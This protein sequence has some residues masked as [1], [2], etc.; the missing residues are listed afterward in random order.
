MIPEVCDA[1]VEVYGDEALHFPETPEEWIE[2]AK[3]FAKRWNFENTLGAMDGK[4]VHIRCPPKAGSLYYNYKQFYSILLLAVVDSA[5]KFIFTDIGSNGSVS[6]TTVFNECGLS[7]ALNANII[8]LLEPK[9]LPHDDHPLPFFMIGDDAFA[10]RTWMMKPFPRSISIP[11]RVFNYRL[12]RARRVWENDL[13]IL[14][15]RFRCLLTT[16]HQHPK[17]VEK[18]VMACCVLH[19]LLTIKYPKQTISMADKEDPKTKVVTPDD[20]KLLELQKLAENTSLQVAK[21]QR[22]CLM[23]YCISVGAVF[24]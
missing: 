1:I 4:D 24:W 8:A 23:G 18:I 6:D 21:I 12:S 14:A 22:N 15:Q 7:Q 10:L 19:N 13:G 9:P 17:R 16:M 20:N 3:G 5:C 11:Q 2:I